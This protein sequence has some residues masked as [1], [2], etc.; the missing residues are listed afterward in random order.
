MTERMPTDPLAYAWPICGRL[1]L[2]DHYDI[3]PPGYLADR[4]P[5]FKSFAECAGSPYVFGENAK[6]VRITA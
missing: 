6:S 4:C 1:N 5:G 3:R 2:P